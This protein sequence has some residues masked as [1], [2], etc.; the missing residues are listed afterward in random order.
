[1]STPHADSDRS[2]ERHD[3][4]ERGYE[5][6]TPRQMSARDWLDVVRRVGAKVGRDDISLVAAGV[7]FY[8]L[9]A[10]PPALA[11]AIALWGLFADPESIEQ[12]ISQLAGALPAQAAQTLRGQLQDVAARSQSTLGWTAILAFLLS[13]WSARAAVTAMMRALNIV[14]GE[15]EKRGFFKRTFTSLALTLGALIGG[16]LALLLVAVVPAIL[17]LVG[18]QGF[19]HVL[20]QLVRW[21]LLLGLVLFAL[22]ALYRFG[23]SRRR[24]RWQWSS[25]GAGIATTL[26]VLASV[27]FSLFVA[28][29]GSYGE[30]Y[31]AITGV[32]VLLLWLWL[33]AYAALIGAE[34]N[35]ELDR[36]TV[37]AGTAAADRTGASSEG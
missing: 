10:I 25:W 26:W 31:G 23:P 28:N 30:T 14:Y 22:A 11:A 17:T 35:A 27:G 24:A 20:V 37:Q 34:L 2:P 1:M 13:L 4:V 18:L 7:A 21:V 36:R 12:Q 19:A 16:V 9:L 8:S 29:F 33:S 32:V 6:V 5:A 3:G 15:E